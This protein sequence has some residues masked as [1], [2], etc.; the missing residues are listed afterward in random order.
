MPFTIPNE[1]DAGV[2]DQAE[3]DKVDI[4]M[5][6]AGVA[7]TGVVSGCAVS[8]QGVPDMTVAVA[9]GVV[10]VNGS[11]VN[12]T[13]GN[14]TVTAAHATLSRFDLIVANSS[15]VKSCVAGTANAN[16][17]FPAIPSLSAVLAAVYVPAADT[18]IG[19]NQIVDKRVTPN[20]SVSIVPGYGTNVRN[21]TATTVAVD[22]IF[23][24]KTINQYYFSNYGVTSAA[25]VLVQDRLYF[26]PVLL[27]PGTIDRIGVDC[28]TGVAS[29]VCRLGIYDSVADFPNA[30]IAEATTTGSLATS[31]TVV[32]LTIAATIPTLAIYWLAVVCQGAVPVAG[33]VRCN[34]SGN[35]QTPTPIGTTAPTSVSSACAS[36]FS[37]GHA[38]ALPA[39]PT[40]S[41]TLIGEFMPRFHYRYS[42]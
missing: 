21:P 5:L 42:A 25:Q 27:P 37:G 8:A 41:N 23:R 20:P 24:T 11:T 13:A 33:S 3:I 35:P 7:G 40:I 4:D 16:A 30:L 2:A 29:L 10:Q 17:V 26:M 1:A 32:N 34:T 39:N 6:V 12:V 15:G 22:S 36:R 9:S 18:A 31:A 28:V 19:A 14:V 38:G